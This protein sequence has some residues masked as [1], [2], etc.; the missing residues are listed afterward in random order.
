MLYCLLEYKNIIRNNLKIMNNSDV[1]ML[2]SM[3]ISVNK[4]IKV[5]KKSYKFLD[6]YLNDLNIEKNDDM[7]ILYLVLFLD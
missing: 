4:G 7:V 6:G 1:G 2:G 3:K 5:N